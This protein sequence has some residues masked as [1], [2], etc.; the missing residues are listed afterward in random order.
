MNSVRNRA[1]GQAVG[2]RLDRFVAGLKVI[3]V[4]KGVVDPV[5]V[6]LPEN[7]VVHKGRPLVVLETEGLEKI[8]IH[9]RRP[10]GDD[11]VDHIVLHHLHVDLHA[12][13]GA[14]APARV[15]MTPHFFFGKHPVID[16]GGVGQI[17]GGEGH[18]LH[19]L[20]DRRRVERSDVNMPNR[21]L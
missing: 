6:E 9:N 19:S 5:D 14:G 10:R 8:H 16:V 20:D 1:G 15:R 21:C 3:L 17:A 11:G 4:D 12:A 2:D 13:P 7:L 18:P